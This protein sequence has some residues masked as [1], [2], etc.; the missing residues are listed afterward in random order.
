VSDTH[1]VSEKQQSSQ[2]SDQKHRA[3]QISG[4]G[5][6][7]VGT[8]S[9]RLQIVA[10]GLL[11]VGG[12][13][14]IAGAVQPSV[15][16][17]ATAALDPGH[18]RYSSLTEITAKNVTDLKPVWAY[19]TGAEGRGWQVSPLAVDGVMFITA[20]GAAVAIDPETGT[21]IWKIKP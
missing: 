15:S 20:P 6:M 19:D 21:Q 2:L 8:V 10:A 1:A 9:S 3:K 17:Q 5:A 13:A 16:S 14:V 11:T 12:L 18:T 7:R 4:N